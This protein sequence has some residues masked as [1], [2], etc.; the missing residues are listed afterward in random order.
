MMKLILIFLIITSFLPALPDHYM[1][2]ESFLGVVSLGMISLI[3]A[4][5]MTPIS[6]IVWILLL[7]AHLAIFCLPFIIKKS[8]FKWVLISAP[9]LFIACYIGLA[10]LFIIVLLLPFIFI[11]LLC[12]MQ[13]R[14]DE[15]KQ[16]YA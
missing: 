4:G 8:Y 12:I 9:V 11:W 3:K 14:A 13:F 1:G 16:K 15:R 5:S 10:S 6:L 2:L 7:I